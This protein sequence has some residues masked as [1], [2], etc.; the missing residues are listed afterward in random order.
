MRKFLGESGA[1]E[2]FAPAEEAFAK[3]LDRVR[4][5]TSS[6]K[7][8][9]DDVGMGCAILPGSPFPFPLISLSLWKLKALVCK[10][11]LQVASLSRQAEEGPQNGM[12]SSRSGSLLGP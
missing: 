12:V 7:N 6:N 5:G 1:D 9:V 4:A 3:V 8:G 10:S 2:Q 11:K